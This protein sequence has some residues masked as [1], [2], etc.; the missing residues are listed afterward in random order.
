MLP[1]GVLNLVY[2]AEQGEMH[3][4]NIGKLKMRDDNDDICENRHGG[5]EFSKKANKSVASK[6][7]KQ[8]QAILA[9]MKKHPEGMTAEEC[10]A[11]LGFHRSSCSARMSE[12]K[13]AGF[14]I[15]LGRRQTK[16]GATAG[17]WTLK[18]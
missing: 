16:S 18:K 15:P 6:K 11:A 1:T 17:V 5:D 3:K 7:E 13:K 12:L 4:E 10:E 8:R 2:Q 14:L 9:V